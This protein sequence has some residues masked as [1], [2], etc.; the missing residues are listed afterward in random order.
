M[1]QVNLSLRQPELDLLDDLADLKGVQRTELVRLL[2]QLGREQWG[3]HADELE[4]FI[5]EHGEMA[6]LEVVITDLSAGDPATVKINGHLV[7]GVWA[8]TRPVGDNFFDVFLA[9]S[10]TQRIWLGQVLQAEG[11]GIVATLGSL[12]GHPGA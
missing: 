3:A 10:W 5:A 6:R 1:P 7:D 2:L 12:H 9:L 11:A 8:V 4:R